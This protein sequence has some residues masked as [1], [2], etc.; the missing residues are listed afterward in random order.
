[1]T[2]CLAGPA[3]EELFCGPI[4]DGSDRIDIAMTRRYLERR[5]EPLRLG[6]E[7]ERMCEAARRLVRVAAVRRQI[8]IIA[9]ALLRHGSLSG[10]E[11]IELLARARLRPF[12]PPCK[13]TYRAAFWRL[14][15][16][17]FE[18]DDEGRGKGN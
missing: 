1:M 17:I 12:W 7:L 16:I 9:E 14:S 3:A 11:I 6:A 13:A 10:D 18:D 8:E 5:V 15:F 2:L 4:T